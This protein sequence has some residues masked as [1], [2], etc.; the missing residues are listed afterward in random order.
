MI[1]V[2]QLRVLALA[3]CYFGASAASAKLEPWTPG[4]FPNPVVDPV[5]CGLQDASRVCDPD[6]VLSLKTR[7]ELSDLLGLIEEDTEGKNQVAVAVVA[8]MSERME[9]WDKMEKAEAFA[10][11]LGDSWGVGIRGLDNGVVLFVSKIDRVAYIKTARGAQE[12]LPDSVVN[13]IIRRMTKEFKK[14][15]GKLDAGVLG[16]VALIYDALKNPTAWE[17]SWLGSLWHFLGE[18]GPILLF[19][20]MGLSF[21]FWPWVAFVCT[22]LFYVAAFPIAWARDKWVEY[23][24]PSNERGGEVD[25]ARAAEEVN[26]PPPPS[27]SSSP[28]SSPSPGDTEAKDGVM[29]EEERKSAED[30]LSR[31]RREIERKA[32]LEPT[33]CCICLEEIKASSHQ[34][35]KKAVVTTKLSCG[36]EFHTECLREWVDSKGDSARC[37]LCRADIPY[38]WDR[39]RS[40][41]AAEQPADSK[42]TNVERLEA[43]LRRFQARFPRWRGGSRRWAP[44]TQARRLMRYGSAKNNWYIHDSD[45]LFFMSRRYNSSNNPAEQP[46]SR[47]YASW[48]SQLP[49]LSVALTRAERRMAEMKRNAAKS[50]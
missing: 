14:D 3:C 50:S 18:M 21:S 42:M 2:L 27:S 31:I 15:E 22:L 48:T 28:S 46:R 12:A 36:H 30:A 9:G 45:W 32:D 6:G 7:V 23:R 17:R 20:I 19:I 40:G 25:E 34:E 41:S 13:R 47:V 35:E 1:R 43:M 24:Y 37:P 39:P 5:R 29:T 16:G 44:R 8:K 10:T 49:D 33:M 11:K 4:M 38:D 26:A